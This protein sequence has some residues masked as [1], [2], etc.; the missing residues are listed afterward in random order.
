M[1]IAT[2]ATT[3]FIATTILIGA[4][5][6]AVVNIVFGGSA[7]TSCGRDGT[8]AA[9]TVAGY[10]PDQLA[11]AATIVAVGEQLNVPEQGWVV[12]IA[13]AMQESGL[14]NLADGDRDSLGL[15]QQRPSQGW[16]TPT[17]VMNPAY[18]ATKFYQRLLTID[19]WQQASINDAAQAVQRSGF[20]AAYARHEQAAR[21]VVA[22]AVG[23]GKPRAIPEDLEQ[24]VST[25]SQAS[26]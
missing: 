1:K 14:R 4:T 17:E 21:A 9:T 12:A 23:S 25:C 15:F 5:S 19:G 22:A 13:T 10:G 18:A 26:G 7:R 8:G 24:S 3:V 16:G 11:N 6:Q 20:P 2:A